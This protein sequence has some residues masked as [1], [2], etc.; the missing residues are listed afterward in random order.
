VAN[1]P[2]DEFYRNLF[3]PQTVLS[4]VPHS[5]LLA[6]RPTSN[7]LRSLWLHKNWSD[8]VTALSDPMLIPGSRPTA[9]SVSGLGLLNPAPAASTLAGLA[10][11]QQPQ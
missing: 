3:A 10:F 11:L 1:R 2:S 5:E 7:T 4:G 8:P 6:P 9:G